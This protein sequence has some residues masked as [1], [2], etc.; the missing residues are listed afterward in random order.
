M[1]K[2]QLSLRL[3]SPLQRPIRS[4]CC[5]VSA[6]LIFMG[7]VFASP[8]LAQDKPCP[9]VPASDPTAAEAAYA[10][11]RF[12]QAENLYGEALAR[13][14]ND[15][16][17]SAG[18]VKTWLR[19]GEIVQAAAQVDKMLMAHPD[20]T[21]TLTS[22]AE[23]QLYQG[24]PWLALETL[25]KAE[26][27]DPCSARIY[28]IRSRA[29]RIDSMYA[30]QREQI[31]KAYD[32]DPTDPD[33]R[34]AWLS[35]VS[36]AREI[37]SIDKSLKTMKDIDPET[38]KLA[39]HSMS[40]MMPLLFENNQTCQVMPATASASFILK[41]MLQDAKHIEGYRL[42]VELPKSKASLI[43]DTAASGLYISR[44]LAEANGLEAAIGDPPGTV[45]AG[46]V[47]IGPLEFL[48][49]VVGVSDITFPG[50]ADGY[51]GTDMFASYLVT[52]DYPAGK[53]ILDPLPKQEG[54]VPGDRKAAAELHG[55]M[56]VYHRQQYL[57]VPA[58]LNNKNRQLF[59]LDSGMR[60][61]T[62]TSD[63][64]HSVSTT[65]VNFTNS[66]Q[67]PSGS[68]LKIYRDSFDFQLANLSLNH[69]GHI[70][71]FDASNIDRNAGMQ[72]AGML[73]FDMLQSFALHLDYRDG[74]V[75]MDGANGE[76]GSGHG[77]GTLT[78]SGLT[79]EEC[80]PFASRDVPLGTVMEGKVSG[81]IDSA[82]LK[83]GKEITISLVNPWEFPEC[84]LE[85]GSLLYGHV[86][87]AS[88]SPAPNASELGLVFDH[89]ECGGHGKR[90]VSL[91][92]VGVLGPPDAFKGLHSALPTEVGGGARSITTLAS[93][94]AYF[95]DDASLNPGGPLR[96]IRPGAVAGI[97]EMK[98]EPTGG[99]ACS[100]KMTNT[101]HSV[102]IG[103]GSE[104]LLTMQS[105]HQGVDQTP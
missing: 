103:T 15:E 51:I 34:H 57:M 69:Q 13:Q 8:V 76:A 45:R 37:E 26:S 77:K 85:S 96:T 47:T 48:D 80:A 63:V 101:Q 84:N 97:S 92:I 33:I 16:K 10:A 72:I 68:T 3:L 61:S 36:P 105:A 29:L 52:L 62:M 90:A 4:A 104:I 42:D 20:S 39:E 64:A 40:S 75:R 2:V 89:A 24:Q 46:S 66:V 12:P 88:S 41:P 82:H 1:F 44:A 81:L 9:V 32:I 60:Y 53:L 74:L 23:V 70:L 78:A 73:G 83:P 100:A 38:K 98:L 17:L 6:G 87:A 21:I 35:T 95:G 99:P 19:E 67:T 30:S 91:A 43:V 54:I 25:K 31:Q 79:E 94:L 18:L 49:C 71:E 27:A 93:S 22:S 7:V 14:P 50:K 55:Y 102:R 56:P 58:V 65:K 28:L 59:I 5:L 86:T 11:A